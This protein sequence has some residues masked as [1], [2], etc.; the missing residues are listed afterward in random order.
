MHYPFAPEDVQSRGHGARSAQPRPHNIEALIATVQREF[1]HLAI[2]VT[3]RRRTVERQAEL[4]V[5]RRRQNRTQFLRTYLPAH[6]ITEM[7]EWVSAHPRATEAETT[8]AFVDIISRAR[9]NG[10]VVSNHLSDHARDISI[11]HGIPQVRHQVRRRLEELGAHVID[12]HDAVG[13]PHWHV[14]Y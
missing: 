12:E 1:P 7:D 11:P 2:R 9:R 6:H 4:M 10:A 14:D 13:G 5:Q 3:G 8:A